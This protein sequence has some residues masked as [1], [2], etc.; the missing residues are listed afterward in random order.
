MIIQLTLPS[1]RLL[2]LNVRQIETFET[3][4]TSGT[5]IK[6]IGGGGFLATEG[7]DEVLQRIAKV[8]PAVNS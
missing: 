8:I 4:G 5:S 3:G 6:L 1:E 2:W 7:P